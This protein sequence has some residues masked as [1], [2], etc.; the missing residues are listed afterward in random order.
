MH[1]GKERSERKRASVASHT[2]RDEIDAS[3]RRHPDRA[4]RKRGREEKN[5]WDENVEGKKEGERVRRIVLEVTRE[6]KRESERALTN[7]R[8]I[9]VM[10]R[11]K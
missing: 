10:A 7:G 6:R 2:E 5:T 8:T 1:L 4:R 9:K 3:A 11:R